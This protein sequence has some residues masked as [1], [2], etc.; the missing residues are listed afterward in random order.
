MDIFT[1]DKKCEVEV[2]RLLGDLAEPALPPDTLTW[3]QYCCAFSMPPAEIAT[4]YEKIAAWMELAQTFSGITDEQIA[5][6]KAQFMT[7]KT[8][9]TD[10][11]TLATG[12][13]AK[14]AA[15]APANGSI[16]KLKKT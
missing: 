3:I 2:L 9:A 10:I 15:A 12:M 11:L 1:C 14:K 16:R 4:H 7:G 6:L 5:T 8:S 13:A